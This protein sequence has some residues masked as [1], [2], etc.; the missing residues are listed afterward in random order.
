M[1]GYFDATEA[2]VSLGFVAMALCWGLV[3]AVLIKVPG[4]AGKVYE[5]YGSYRQAGLD[6]YISRF[7]PYRVYHALVLGVGALTLSVI[8]LR[9]AVDFGYLPETLGVERYLL[10]VCGGLVA[11]GVIWLWRM[12]SFALWSYVFMP[13]DDAD[14]LRQDYVLLQVLELVVLLPLLLVSLSNIPADAKLWCIIGLVGL[15]QLWRIVQVCRRLWHRAGD[16]IYI[17]LYLCT[18]EIT[19]LAY[20]IALIGWGLGKL[21][22]AS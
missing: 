14:L 18:H 9:L 21:Q 3:L 11:Q 7:I 12:L 16:G 8:A 6:L 20:T 5:A 13:P 10:F 2:F 4:L 17:F 15:I 1:T 19:P 22:G